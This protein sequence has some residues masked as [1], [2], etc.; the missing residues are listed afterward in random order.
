M[1][2]PLPPLNMARFTDGRVV[3]LIILKAYTLDR[4]S[5]DFAPLE[6]RT[7]CPPTNSL[8]RARKLPIRRFSCLILQR[9]L[10]LRRNM[11]N[12]FLIWA[13]PTTNRQTVHCSAVHPLGI[14][15][16]VS[17]PTWPMGLATVKALHLSVILET[18]RAWIPIGMIMR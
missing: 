18:M 10:H 13:G 17:R 12:I 4:S 16:P 1:A 2:L 14:D 7:S 3:C 8:L 9:T 15:F 6:H 5:L 11:R